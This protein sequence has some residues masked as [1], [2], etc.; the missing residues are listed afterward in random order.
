MDF[1]NGV[2][3]IQAAGYYGARTVPKVDQPDVK[4][5]KKVI[6]PGRLKSGVSAQDRNL[7]KSF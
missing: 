6:S 5:L 2:M 3:N 4:K 7:T 1:K